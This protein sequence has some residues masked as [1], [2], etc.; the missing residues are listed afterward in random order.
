MD[1]KTCE[2]PGKGAND[3]VIRNKNSNPI[4]HAPSVPSFDT[5]REKIKV[6][7]DCVE[8]NHSWL[9]GVQGSNSK[10]PKDSTLSLVVLGTDT[11][12]NK[13]LSS[14]LEVRNQSDDLGPSSVLNS[15]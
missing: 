2:W 4:K 1:C 12:L 11:N 15:D 8:I 9:Q 14:I 6:E 7:V 3:E 13:Q 10:L 5:G